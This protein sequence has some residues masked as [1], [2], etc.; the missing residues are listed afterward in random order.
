[1]AIAIKTLSV[2]IVLCTT[3]A[4]PVDNKNDESLTFYNPPITNDDEI[5]TEP[6][7]IK[8]VFMRLTRQGKKCSYN[9]F[10]ILIALTQISLLS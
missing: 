2:V 8:D 10:C 7:E 1:M 6:V 9:F 4:L 5:D 3:N